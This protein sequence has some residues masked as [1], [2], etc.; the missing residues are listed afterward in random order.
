MVTFD[1]PLPSPHGST[2]LINIAQVSA[3]SSGDNEIL[4][5]LRRRTDPIGKLK[6]SRA[7]FMTGCVCGWLVSDF[8]GR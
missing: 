2:G 8:R 6:C 4:S 5:Q 3:K 7:V 1:P